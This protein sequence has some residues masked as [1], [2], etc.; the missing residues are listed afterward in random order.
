MTE[1]S[2][3]PRLPPVPRRHG[4]VSRTAIMTACEVLTWIAFGEAKTRERL[5]EESLARLMNG[6]ARDWWSS[7]PS[8]QHAWNQLRDVV[9]LGRKITAYGKPHD[10]K[11]KPNECAEHTPIPPSVFMDKWMTVTVRDSV[12]PDDDAPMD[13]W[14]SRRGRQRYGDVRFE[15]RD[16]LELWPLDPPCAEGP[17]VEALVTI[18][19]VTA[20]PGVAKWMLAYAKD[21]IATRG[22]PCK[23]DDALSACQQ[24]L[25]CTYRVAR[26]AWNDL[27]GDLKRKP[28][29]TDRALTGQRAPAAR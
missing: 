20:A 22:A 1:P 17:S 18:A 11:C 28:R 23:R 14:A 5:C 21:T 27:P 26:A 7:D 12:E 8:V 19:P 9:L 2:L 24:A 16:V 3:L 15:T 6:V 25:K 13:R 29:Q 10:A 4:V